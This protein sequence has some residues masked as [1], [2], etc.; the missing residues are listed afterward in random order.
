MKNSS[1]WYGLHHDAL[2]HVFNKDIE[3][4]AKVN[5]TKLWIPL[6]YLLHTPCFKKAYLIARDVDNRLHSK[7]SRLLL[8]MHQHNTS[9]AHIATDFLSNSVAAFDAL[10]RKSWAECVYK[11]ACLNSDFLLDRLLFPF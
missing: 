3:S 9:L 2:N 4:I 8:L 11:T 1:A 6:C 5:V 7:M 10:Q